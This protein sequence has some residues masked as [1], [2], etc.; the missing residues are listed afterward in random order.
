MSYTEI[1][2]RR[3]AEI[4][5][6]AA[7]IVVLAHS[8]AALPIPGWHYLIIRNPAMVIDFFAL[9]SA[10]CGVCSLEKR[11]D[12]PAFYLRRLKRMLPAYY[13][14]VALYALAGGIT[15]DAMLAGHIVPLCVWTEATWSTFWYVPAAL[16]YYMIIPI[17]HRAMK[18]AR[19]PVALYRG[20]LAL[21]IL[22]LPLATRDTT[23]AIAL[24]RVHSVITG[25][26]LGV[27]H[28][29][30]RA[31]EAR[32]RDLI[33]LAALYAAGFALMTRRGALAR[34]P[35]SLWDDH[36][37]GYLHK[38][39]RAP[40]F[41]V[42]LAYGFELTERTPLR[43]VN[44]ALRALG[45]RSMELYAVHVPIRH[46]LRARLGMTGAPLMLAMLALSIPL[47]FALSELTAR[48][49]SRAERRAPINRTE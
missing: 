32:L 47:A 37:L 35:I 10:F 13:V 7:L 1:L 34:L 39:L 40:L 4:M 23:A 48:L 27:F 43:R 3:R 9:L 16:L 41:A 38:G 42:A 14:G 46:A 17:V 21:A 2:S 26:A 6:I 24:M 31:R 18:D 36:Q 8:Y 11:P 44:R 12:F 45:A 28:H 25:T 19:H 5:G 15:T 49:V 33:W 22:P 29:T 30:H 20:L